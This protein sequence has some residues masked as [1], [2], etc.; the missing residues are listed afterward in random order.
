MKLK[1]R[2]LI[3]I[4]GIALFLLV[5]CN[6]LA[7]GA[8]SSDTEQKP[9]PQSGSATPKV[10]TG[11]SVPQSNLQEKLEPGEKE[12]RTLHGP[13]GT[14][15]I[16]TLGEGKTGK[17]EFERIQGQN[18]RASYQKKG[19]SDNVVYS[20]TFKGQDIVKP[21]D[22]DMSIDFPDIGQSAT[23]LVKKLINPLY[24]SFAHSGELPGKASVYVRVGTQYKE[25]DLLS[26]YYYNPENDKLELAAGNIKVQA[27]YA[28][29]ELTHC[30]DYFLAQGL[31]STGNSHLILWAAAGVLLV[32]CA[33]LAIVIYRRKKRQ[34]PA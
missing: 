21:A 7:L 20:W 23:P 32:I 13:L 30:S 15:D 2:Q 28:I 31:I 9:V 22:I 19:S 10:V 18:S 24:I 17:T 33:G 16:I 8:Q 12:R 34:P 14:V 1:I 29:M 5:N 6:N 11:K 25:G 26:L 3:K 4:L 27:G